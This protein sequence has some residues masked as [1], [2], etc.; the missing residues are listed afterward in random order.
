[1]GEKG[2]RMKHT[3][4]GNFPCLP[5]IEEVGRIAQELCNHFSEELANQLDNAIYSAYALTEEEIK[6]IQREAL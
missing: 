1:M 5:L 4:F 6:E 3:F 2:I